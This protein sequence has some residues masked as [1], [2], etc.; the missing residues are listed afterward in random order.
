MID[1]FLTT[2]PIYLMIAVGYVAVRTGYLDGAHIG[3]LSQFA[4]KV[5]RSQ[6]KPSGSST[7]T[8]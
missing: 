8:R 5:T 4:L 2:L 1:I 7:L 6:A 3:G